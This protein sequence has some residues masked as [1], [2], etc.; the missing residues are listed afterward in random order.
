MPGTLGD[1]LQGLNR[2][3]V[4]SNALVPSLWLCGVVAL[5]LMMIGPAVLTDPVMDWISFSLGGS[6]VATTLGLKVYWA[7]WYPHRLQ[8]ETFQRWF[9]RA[10]IQG[11]NEPD[12][13]E[14]SATISNPVAPPIEAAPP[15]QQLTASTEGQ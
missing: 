12:V 11:V 10:T 2:L 7:I 5:P 15:P 9:H 3:R 14:V 13:I 4:S 8:S 1:A 6:I